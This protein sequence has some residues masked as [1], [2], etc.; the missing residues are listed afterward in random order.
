MSIPNGFNIAF[1]TQFDAND[2]ERVFL[3][4]TLKCM[5]QCI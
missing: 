1:E 2:T 3:L 5:E 4:K